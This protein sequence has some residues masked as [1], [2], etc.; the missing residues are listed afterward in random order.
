MDDTHTRPDLSFATQELATT[1][2]H[3]VEKSEAHT[4]V[5]AR[6]AR[7]QV[8]PTSEKQYLEATRKSTTKPGRATIQEE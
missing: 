8:H 6:Y 5:P 7:P 1:N 3:Q 4:E 2:I